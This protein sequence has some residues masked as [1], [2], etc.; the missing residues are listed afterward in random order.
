MDKMV[1]RMEV[2]DVEDVAALSAEL[3]YPTTPELVRER[4]A[5]ITTN[6]NAICYVATAC[7]SVAGWTHAYAVFLIESPPYAELGGLVVSSGFKRQGIGS[8]LVQAAEDR[9][10][11]DGLP[12]RYRRSSQIAS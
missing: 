6:G 5:R 12:R 3:G 7:G 2:H 11:W 9:A 8:A 1:R 4:L 10:R